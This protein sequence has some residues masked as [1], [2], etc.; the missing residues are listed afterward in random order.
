MQLDEQTHGLRTKKALLLQSKDDILTMLGLILFVTPPKPLSIPTSQSKFVLE[1]GFPQASEDVKELRHIR[2]G[3]P[4]K[5]S[6]TLSYQ[7]SFH[8]FHCWASKVGVELATRPL[9]GGAVLPH[10]TPKLPGV[11]GIVARHSRS[12]RR[13]RRI[14]DGCFNGGTTF[15]TNGTYARGGVPFLGN[16]FF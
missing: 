4:N 10:S 2:E 11:V 3:L 1:K 14:P 16:F 15:G 7:A 8:C 6:I 13:P 5:K 9:Y 12:R